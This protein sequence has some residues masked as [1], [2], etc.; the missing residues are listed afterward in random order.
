[1]I[2]K[3]QAALIIASVLGM[4]VLGVRADVRY[5]DVFLQDYVPAEAGEVYR[6]DLR[7]EGSG[8]TRFETQ[9]AKAGD[10]PARLAE[11]SATQIPFEVRCED[12]SK[13]LVVVFEYNGETVVTELDLS[14]ETYLLHTLPRPAT[15]YEIFAGQP[16]DHGIR[17]LRLCPS[18]RTGTLR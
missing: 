14:R 18:K 3:W 16:R 2:R 1:V 11:F 17:S 6:G 15:V 9:V 4:T 13:P 7:V 10:V 5:F 12:P 8:W